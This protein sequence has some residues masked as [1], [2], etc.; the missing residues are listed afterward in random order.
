MRFGNEQP[1]KLN[2]QEVQTQVLMEFP[3]KWDGIDNENENEF[4]ASV[5][6][7][8]DDELLLFGQKQTQQAEL[9]PTKTLFIQSVTMM[10]QAGQIL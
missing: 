10:V 8:N 7:A 1:K 4:R 9:Q 2:V 5:I 6:E 3:S